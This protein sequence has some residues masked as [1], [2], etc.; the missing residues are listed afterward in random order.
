MKVEEITANNE[1]YLKFELEE[2]KQK[3][4]SFYLAKVKAIDFLKIFTVRPA[5]YDLQKHTALANSFPDEKTYYEHLI[6]EDTKRINKKDFQR[7][8]DES[9][10]TKIHKFISEEE[11]AFFPNTIISNCELINDLENFSLDENSNENEFFN[12]ANKPATICFFR[13]VHEK[14]FLYVPKK[15]NTILVI[16]GQHRLEGLQKSTPDVQKDYDLIIAF[17][18]GF[19]RSVIAKQFYTINYEQKSVNKSLLYQ[20]TGEFSHD[21]DEL[22]F[23][24][25][26]VKLLNELSD[27][28]FYARVKMLGKTPKNVPQEIKE[29]LSISQAF[30]IDSSIRLISSSAIGTSMPPIFLKYYKNKSEHINIIKTIARFFNAVE[31]IQ[32]DWNSP[33]ESI[34]SK[35]MGVAALL[36]VLNIIFPIIFVKEMGERWEN[37]DL[38]K[39]PDFQRFLKGLE[40]VDFSSN[41]LYGKTGSGGSISKIKNDILSKLEYIGKPQDLEVFETNVRWSYLKK[42]NTSLSSA[43]TQI[44]E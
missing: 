16:D 41:G 32:P 11:Y 8:P 7:E 10:I 26:S 40:N 19:D 14:C 28:P 39:V 3:S 13:R 30:L 44:K 42:F 35:G 22:T 23:L 5:Q 2:F 25:N 29:K 33:K 21:L 4:N 34:I 20:L 12:K 36:R 15:P 17:I 9:R 27:S 37:V 38:L 24:H 18:I 31:K 6:K 1:Q 43:L